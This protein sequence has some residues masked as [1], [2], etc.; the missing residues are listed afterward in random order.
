MAV[1]WAK[2]PKE[3][4]PWLLRLTEEFDL[5]FPLSDEE[6]NLVPCLLPD[7]EKEVSELLLDPVN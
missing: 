1:V 2:Y 7:T 6:A 5:T 4:H 3:L